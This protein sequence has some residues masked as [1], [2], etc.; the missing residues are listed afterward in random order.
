MNANRQRTL[1]DVI[2][3]YG[4]RFSRCLSADSGSASKM[5]NSL[6]CT[7]AFPAVAATFLV[8]DE[9]GVT[10]THLHSNS[11]SSFK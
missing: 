9:A 11:V 1:S 3:Y 7:F 5:I 2:P 8:S 6:V 10:L 4:I